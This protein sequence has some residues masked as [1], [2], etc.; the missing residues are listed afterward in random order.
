MRLRAGSKHCKN[1][2]MQLV[3]AARMQR[4]TD[5][6]LRDST[7]KEVELM[8]V[9]ALAKSYEKSETEISMILGNED[10][11]K[12]FNYGSTNRNSR[13]SE[14]SKQGKCGNCDRRHESGN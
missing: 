10:K 13:I 3:V 4:F 6:V 14:D 7:T 8:E 5:K 2:M 11:I 12:S 9:L 1:L